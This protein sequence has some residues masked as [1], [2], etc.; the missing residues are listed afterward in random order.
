MIQ[1]QHLSKAFTDPKRGAVRAV[2]G[3]SFEVRKGEIF[4]LLGPNGAGKTT[5]LRLLATVMTP[6]AG[7][8]VLNGH[9]VVRSPGEVRRQI[10]FLSGDMGLYH[11]LT[12]REILAF[13]GQLNGL[14]GAALKSRI[15][16]MVALLDMRSFADTK[17]DQL[18]TGM[19]QRVAIARTLIHDPPILILDEPAAGLDVPTARVIEEF[20][21][22]A[23]R[24]GKCILLSTHVMEE[25]EFL[26]DRIAVIHQGRIR[27]T[28]TMEE[29]RA[30]TG[31][32]RL[33]GIFLA[34]LG[35][36]VDTAGRS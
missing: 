35:I 33:R 16:E 6:T 34:L 13:F 1:V 12:P 5:T 15:A 11:R 22:E 23:R 31:K 32:Q 18:S 17:V 9:D 2:D 36:D 30:A 19:R 20:I 26:C 28:G 14:D 29:L 24:A 21:L 4:G 7:T 8:A 10:G 27:I 25:A 3:V